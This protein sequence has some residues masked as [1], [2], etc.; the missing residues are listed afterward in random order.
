MVAY[1]TTQVFRLASP[2]VVV[3]HRGKPMTDMKVFHG[4]TPAI[5]ACLKATSERSPGTKYVPPD[6]NK[7][8]A[9][10]SIQGHFPSGI[11]IFELGFEFDPST[12]DLGYTLIR[13]SGTLPISWA[14]IQDTI[15]SCRT[16]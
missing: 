4:V 2:T 16:S 13:K 14:I 3:E 8:T 6:A 10:I 7:G 9:T 15:D 1:S 5:F 12:G 11:S